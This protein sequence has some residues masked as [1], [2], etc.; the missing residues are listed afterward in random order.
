MIARHALVDVIAGVELDGDVVVRVLAL[1]GVGRSGR[2][3]DDAVLV[4]ET[5][6]GL[7]RA[8]EERVHGADAVG[9]RLVVRLGGAGD[10]VEVAGRDVGDGERVV[11][12]L[13]A[14]L[15]GEERLGLEVEVAAA[16]E[17]R[18]RRSEGWSGSCSSRPVA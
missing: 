16:E 3:R 10:V 14:G 6:D 1:A 13:Q 9:D 12:G 7:L 17:R 4:G 18:G 5:D 2:H 11:D 15:E 8:A